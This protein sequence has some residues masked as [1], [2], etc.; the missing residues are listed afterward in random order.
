MQN[1]TEKHWNLFARELMAILAAHHIPLAALDQYISVLP[2]K[3]RR[4]FLSLSLPNNF[5]VLSYDEI[6]QLVQVCNLTETEYIRLRAALVVTAI[7]KLLIVRLQ[8]ED[9]LQVADIAFPVIVQA[10]L[11][12]IGTLN[13]FDSGRRGDLMFA[14]DDTEDLALISAWHAIDSGTLALNLSYQVDLHS[15]RLD[16]AHEA[17]WKFKQAQVELAEV[18]AETRTTLSWQNWSAETE[19]GL[20]RV[21]KRLEDLSDL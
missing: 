18:D 3:V 11:R 17:H 19:R 13:P 14:E 6:D 16:S 8:P 10:L 1:R 12:R 4:L 2:E 15:E 21:Q 5:P 9:A 20:Q 7:E